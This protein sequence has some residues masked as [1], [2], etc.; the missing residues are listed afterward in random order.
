MTISVSAGTDSTSRLLGSLN[1]RQL[2]AATHDGETLLILAGAGTGKTTTLCG[3]A[4]WLISQGHSPERLL[5]VTF[6]RRAAHELVGRARGQ[7]GTVAGVGTIVGGTFHSLAHRFV[8]LHAGALGLV[9]GFGV[10]DA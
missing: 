8:R 3:R 2:E 6:T 9:G 10:L 1:D 7:A 5:L 4:S